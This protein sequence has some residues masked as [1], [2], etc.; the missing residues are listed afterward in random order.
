M[1]N[2]V[3]LRLYWKNNQKIFDNL[4]EEWEKADTAFRGAPTSEAVE[5][6][7]AAEKVIQIFMRKL[8]LL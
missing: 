8:G 3:A 7:E 2:E 4:V 6:L 5:R 1:E